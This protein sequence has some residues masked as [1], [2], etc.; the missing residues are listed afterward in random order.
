M[1]EVEVEPRFTDKKLE[2]LGKIKENA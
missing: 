1:T 2:E